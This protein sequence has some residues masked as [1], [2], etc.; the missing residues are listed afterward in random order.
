MENETTLPTSF[1]KLP[2]G[3]VLDLEVGTK[4]NFFRERLSFSTAFF[5]EDLTNPATEDADDDMLYVTDGQEHIPGV[6][7]GVVGRVTD[8]WQVLLNYTY[9][10][11]RVVSS[12]DPAL[13]GNP[14]LNAP[15][16]TVA[17]WTTYNLPWKFQVGFGVNHVSSRVAAEEP[18][19]PGLPLR[20]GPGYTIES[21]LL[22][23]QINSH[24]DL[25]MNVTNLSNEDYIDG[26]HPGHA[27]PG[28]G[29]TFYFSTNF[30]F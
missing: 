17:L 29:R 6:E 19:A 15:D 4:W 1:G 8:D 16:N 27:V 13:V 9:M 2:V 20:G 24:L 26:I 22:K 3:R 21:A 25:Q 18:D 11:A 7:F 5:W 23:Y 10:H 30:K 12:S 28:E 14:V